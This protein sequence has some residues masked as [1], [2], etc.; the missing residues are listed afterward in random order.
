MVSDQCANN[1]CGDYGT[2]YIINSQLN[3]VSAC[4]CA[5]GTFSARISSEVLQVTLDRTLDWIIILKRLFIF[6]KPKSV[7]IYPNFFFRKRF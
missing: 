3:L 5:G 2:C 7:F 1:Y 4:K 6:P